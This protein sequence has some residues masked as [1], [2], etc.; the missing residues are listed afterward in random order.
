MVTWVGFTPFYAAASKGLYSPTQVEISNFSAVYDTQRALVEKRTDAACV[1]LLDAVRMT[2]QGKSIKVV[3]VVDYSSGADAIVARD[4]IAGVRG[5][6]GRRVA[7]E[8]GTLTHFVLL[9]ALGRAGLQESD[10][11]VVNLAIEEGATAFQ[12]GSVDAA[13]LWE[14]FVSKSITAGGHRIFTSKEIP[15]EILDVVV[16]PGDLPQERVK[17]VVQVLRGW[18]EALRL[19]KTRPAEVED[20]MARSLNVTVPELKTE[21]TG[22]ELVDLEHNR[23]L[24][25]PAEKGPSL[26]SAYKET[27]DFMT[28]HKILK[29]PPPDAPEVIDP[30]FL[31]EASGKP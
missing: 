13:V 7:A 17:D 6:K 4:G 20:V 23:R 14:P 2:A 22:I 28:S 25:D 5:L 24:F 29:T 27:A 3:M 19:W 8:V 30:R 31:N 11:T 26:W 18:E 10:V 9:K 21:I 12:K 1:A 15:G 16:V